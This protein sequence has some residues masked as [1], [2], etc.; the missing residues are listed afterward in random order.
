M[1]R[2]KRRIITWL[3]KKERLDKYP[4]LRCFFW[5]RG[6]IYREMEQRAAQMRQKELITVAFMVLDLPCWK[7]D[8]VFRLMQQHPR[9]RPIIWIVPELQIKDAD[10]RQRKLDE[11][12]RQFADRGYPVADMYS[13]EQ[14]RAEYAPDIVFLAKPYPGVTSWNAWNLDRELIC[15]VPYCYQNTCRE[16]FLYG[17]ENHV[18]RNFYA[19]RGVG[20]LATSLMANGGGNVI[21][22]GSPCADSFLHAETA[23]QHTA[24]KRC[25]PGM[26]KVIWAPHWTVMGDSFFSVSTFLNVADGMLQLAEKYADRI[27]WAFKPHPLL[28]DSLYQH[29][30]W[31]KERTDAYYGRW[32]SMP[33]SQLET[34][35]YVELF[36]QSDAMVHDSGSFIMEYLLVD[37][38]C[39][40][41]Q[42]EGS[43]VDFN[44]DT[45]RALDCYRKG[46]SIEDV[47]SFLL[48]LLQGKPDAM[49]RPR[50]RYRKSSL[51]PPRGKTAAQNII[52]VI[53]KGW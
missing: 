30:D 31:G 34:G 53:L 19:T 14:M 6:P 52:D 3:T 47:E 42:L 23:T 15:Y 7:C 17:R 35:A 4:F 39:M 37:K 26:K 22:T 29:P 18:W 48:D 10:E 12:R 45:Q 1:K 2:M 27:Q 24:W 16:D 21:T 49:A 9:F 32:E 28:R 43:S 40:Y 41:L 20:R 46:K 50:A 36:K 51:I 11:L 38:P 8:S 25:A 13:L 44:E 33:N 5:K